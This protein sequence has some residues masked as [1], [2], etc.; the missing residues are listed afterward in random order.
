MKLKTDGDK[1]IH[2][3]NQIYRICL[4][5][6]GQPDVDPNATV[7]RIIAWLDPWPLK[8]QPDLVKKDA[9]GPS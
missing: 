4:D 5:H 6:L 1:A 2:T 8:K 3:L 9:G 7:S